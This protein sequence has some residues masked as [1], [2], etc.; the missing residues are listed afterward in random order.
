MIYTGVDQAQDQD[1]QRKNNREKQPVIHIKSEFDE[2][3]GINCT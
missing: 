1:K 2:Q 3:Y